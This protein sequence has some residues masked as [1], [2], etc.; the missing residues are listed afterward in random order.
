MDAKQILNP[1]FGV[2]IGSTVTSGTTK[3]KASV[4]TQPVSK[5]VSQVE[6]QKSM[7]GESSYVYSDKMNQ[8]SFGLCGAY[9][10][11]GVS[12][13]KSSLSAYVGNSSATATK[14]ITVSY[15]AQSVAGV[16]YIDFQSLTASD[17]LASLDDAT[18]QNA[19]GVLDAFNDV[20]KETAKLDLDLN[21]LDENDGRF[22]ELKPY[23]QKWIDLSQRFCTNFGDGIV[24]G[25]TWG[26]MGG[27]IMEMTS[28]SES[29]TWKYGGKAD[30]SYASVG[31]SVAVKSTYDGGTS[32][33]YANVTVSCNSY[34]SGSVLTTQIDKWFE[35]VSNKT[36]EQ[37]ADVKVMAVAP[38]MTI[39]QGPPTI[40]DFVKPKPSEGISSKV[41][42]IK[43][44]DGLKAFATASAFDQAKK[45]NPK[46]TLKEFIAE[47][48]QP[49]NIDA[50][51]ELQDDVNDNNI[52]VLEPNDELH[53]NLL[54]ASK[55]E[56]LL[57][58]NVSTNANLA[59]Y[60]P[61]GVWI[62]N[63]ADI[64]PWMA[65]GY[66][67]N[68]EYIEGSEE[69][70]KRVLLQDLQ[71][72]ARLYLTA[73]AS[74]IKKIK[75]LNRSLPDVKTYDIAN[76]FSNAAGEL[77]NNY[78][79]DNI[80]SSIIQSLGTIIG[81]IY[82]FW[83]ENTFLRNAELALGLIHEVKEN[84][85]LVTKSVSDVSSNES[86]DSKSYKL[87]SNLFEA[88]SG[89][90]EQ[91][92]STLKVLPLITPDKEL[93]AFGPEKGGLVSIYDH[94]ITFSKPSL[95]K[96]IK[97]EANKDT[98]TLTNRDFNI[99]LYPIPYSAAAGEHVAWKGISLS[100][101]IRAEK[102]L[103]GSLAQMDTQLSGLKEWS[104]SSDNWDKSWNGESYYVQKKVKKH[105]IG[106][107]DEISNVI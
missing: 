67:N 63:W 97:F 31:S 21:K 64:F 18:R 27:I 74:G 92:A 39:N 3:F 23:L 34:V 94:E 43:D 10:I 25:V 49:A 60:V 58:Q 44:L 106:L 55:S 22:F 103:T 76:G 82:K 7:S 72:L 70:R 6:H 19:L 45:L 77:Q 11:S 87:V 81:D 56:R 40:P 37:L 99:T 30:F 20:V 102:S 14:S 89:N 93:W 75:R 78:H 85:Q 50:L 61:L 83:N 41:G 98:K 107:I 42:E 52:N 38:N 90:Y 1:L 57:S 8:G 28:G 54:L 48:E 66:L 101:N 71:T 79:K 24:V 29:E 17:F 96:F 68:V 105:Y 86:A 36:F 46:L 91:F 84:G 59:D 47:S 13:V 53:Q 15:N 100:T 9:G 62:S 95:A 65:Q 16:E 4:L 2:T 88:A 32:N 5:M 35:Q 80:L 12:Q 104:F 73:D 51:E 26:A 69:I 33:N